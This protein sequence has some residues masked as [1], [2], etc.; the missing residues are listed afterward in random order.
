MPA[1]EH[2]ASIFSTAAAVGTVVVAF[3]VLG[4]TRFIV[5]FAAEPDRSG[6]GRA[7]ERKRTGARSVTARS[8]ST[9]HRL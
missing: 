8:R 9:R 1:S 4:L 6:S 5:R 2:L 3:A 7:G